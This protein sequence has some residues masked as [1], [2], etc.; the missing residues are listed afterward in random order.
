VPAPRAVDAATLAEAVGAAAGPVLLDFTAAWC[1]PCRALEPVL[2]D[3]AREEPDLTVLTIDA[4]AAPELVRR[5]DVMSFPT[6][7]LLRDGVPVR[8]LVGARGKA[9][10]REELHRV[11]AGV[12]A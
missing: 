1:G 5:Y 2:H 10:L 9:R 12:D 7:L 6:L 4:D 8:R 3:L 11:R